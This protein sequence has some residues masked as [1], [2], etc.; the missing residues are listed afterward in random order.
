MKIETETR[1]IAAFWF[2]FRE[3]MRQFFKYVFRVSDRYTLFWAFQTQSRALE[4][5]RKVQST[6]FTVLDTRID[7]A[8]SLIFKLI[9]VEAR[10]RFR[11][12]MCVGKRVSHVLHC[13]VQATFD[14]QV[15]LALLRWTSVVE[16]WG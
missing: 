15:H 3:A 4:L 14:R 8:Q 12:I 10:L 6:V 13:I 1:L 9:R 7:R 11:N 5:G 16:L 2:L